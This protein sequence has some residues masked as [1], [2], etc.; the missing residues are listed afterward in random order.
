MISVLGKFPLDRIAHVGL[1]DFR[2]GAM[3]N[4][5]LVTYRDIY[6]LVTPESS[7]RSKILSSIVICHETSHF[8]FGNLV[9]M[10][11]FWK[12]F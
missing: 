9:T 12:C 10:V 6:I 11:I 5:G 3:E 7:M 4:F 2:S 1:P 8:Y